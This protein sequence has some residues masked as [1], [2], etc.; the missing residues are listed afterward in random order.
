VARSRRDG[1]EPG[2]QLGPPPAGEAAAV[3]KAIALFD[4]GS[5]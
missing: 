5:D 2:R 3:L 4:H 1:V